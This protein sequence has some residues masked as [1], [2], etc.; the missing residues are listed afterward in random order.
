MKD[1]A[2]K[3]DRT[4]DLPRLAAIY[5]PGEGGL[6]RKSDQEWLD[7]NYAGHPMT[8]GGAGIVTTI[9]DYMRFARMLLGDGAVGDAR[10]L[11]PATVKLIMTDQLDPR[12]TERLWLPSKGAV[13]Y[14]V[15]GA[16]RIAQPQTPTE[17]RGT[18]GE[19]IWD[20]A[21]SV[22]FW[23]D[24]VNDLAVVFMTQRQPNDITLHRDLRKAI[25]GA[26]Y[27]GPVSD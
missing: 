12:I 7:R 8:E 10:I 27:L 21:S 6:T 16:V 13:G 14:G 24:P 17:D 15:N 18:V 2:W 23:V 11:K 26:D 4:A 25:Y 19:Y 20:G 5:Q 22:L 3:R 9:D 1:S